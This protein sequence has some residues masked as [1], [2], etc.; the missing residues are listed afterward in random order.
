VPHPVGVVLD[1]QRR[2]SPLELVFTRSVTD[3]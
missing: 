3:A 2:T 1:E